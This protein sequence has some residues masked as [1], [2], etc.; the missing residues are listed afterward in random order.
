MKKMERTIGMQIKF[1]Q[2]HLS[3]PLLCRRDPKFPGNTFGLQRILALTLT[4]Y[5]VCL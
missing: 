5:F 3:I 4:V 1:L 2:L